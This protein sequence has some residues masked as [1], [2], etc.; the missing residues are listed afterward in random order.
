MDSHGHGTLVAG[1]AAADEFVAGGFRGRGVAPGANLVALRVNDGVGA[2][3]DANMKLALGWVIDNAS[4]L[5]ITV[6]NLSLGYGHWTQ[7]IPNPT[8]GPEL[9][10][11]IS[12]GIVVVAASGNGTNA[13]GHGM[14]YPAI[15]PNVIAVGAVDRFDVITEFTQRSDKL[16]ILAP[17]SEVPGT[18][19]NGGFVYGQGTSFAAPYVSGAIAILRAVD[20]TFSL[21]DLRSILR[22]SSADNFDGDSEFGSFTNLTFPRLNL[23]AM[24][25]LAE[26]RK[27]NLSITDSVIGK[28]GNNNDIRVDAF[29]LQ[30]FMWFDSADRTLKYAVRNT[31]GGWSSIGTPDTTSIDMGQYVSL[32]LDP[33][34]RPAIAYFDGNAGDLRFARYIE[35]DWAR[36]TVDFRFSVGLY[37]NLAYV[38]EKPVITYYY[39]TGGDLRLAERVNGSWVITELDTDGDTG[40]SGALTFDNDG[41]LALAY[42][43]SGLGHLKLARQTGAGWSIET[44]DNTTAGV[45]FISMVFDKTNRPAIS[46]Y[47]ASPADLKYARHTGVEWQR[48]VLATKGAVGLYTRIWMDRNDRPNI[49][50]FNRTRNL[51]LESKQASNGVWSTQTIHNTGGRYIAAAVRAPAVEDHDPEVLFSWY[52]SIDRKLVLQARFAT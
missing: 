35:S 51:L 14:M 13:T 42:E 36:E 34:G 1:I 6:V 16:D 8:F 50:Y 49:L 44:V 43:H 10:Q 22:T 3:S 18:G 45:A 31:A 32:A 20:S 33:R 15:D 29:G 2:A 41:K 9:Q 17:G 26:F 23:G 5:N 4:R 48:Q 52:D 24:A 25:K 47:D 19:L 30:H 38:G 11:V 46:Y 27:T 37:P 7:A 28:F 12:L 40:R 39:K 21:P